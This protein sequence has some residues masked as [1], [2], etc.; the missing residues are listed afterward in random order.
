[1]R[2][3]FAECVTSGIDDVA[4][5]IKVWLADFEMNDIAPLCFERFRFNENFECR[6]GAETRHAM[7]EPKL[8]CLSHDVK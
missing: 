8:V 5:R 4:R 6:F 1:V 3:P 2:E 7:S